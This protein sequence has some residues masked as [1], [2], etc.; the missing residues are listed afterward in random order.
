MIYIIFTVEGLIEAE[1]AVIEDQADLWINPELVYAPELAAFTAAGIQMH[2]LP[3]PVDIRNEKAVLAAMA[4][5][6]TQMPGKE[7]LIEFV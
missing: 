1:D 7:I 4:Y 5:V 2:K 6:E 3:E